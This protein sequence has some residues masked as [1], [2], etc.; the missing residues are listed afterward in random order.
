MAEGGPGTTARR[1]AAGRSH[2]AGGRE[3][4]ARG[5]SQANDRL[6]YPCSDAQDQAPGDDRITGGGGDDQL[7]GG[8][9]RVPQEADT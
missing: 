9:D 2:C 6:D 8:P 7:T 4:H 5:W 3:R 1:T